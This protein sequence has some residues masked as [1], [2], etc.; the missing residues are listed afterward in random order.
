MRL[1]WQR[2]DE[3][4][5]SEE[6]SSSARRSYSSLS[7]RYEL[8]WNWRPGADLR[9]GLQGEYLTRD[10]GVSGVGQR[11][12]ALKGTGRRRLLAKWTL[13]GEARLAEVKSDEPAGS[14]RPWF[15]SYP[16]RNIDASLR[17]AWDPTEYLS[18]G[19][20]LVCPQAGGKGG[21]STMSVWN[22]PP[23]SETLR[24]SFASAVRAW[25]VRP[26]T[27]RSSGWWPD[28]WPGMLAALLTSPAPVSAAEAPV[29]VLAP[30][31]RRGAAD[32]GRSGC[33]P[34]LAGE[35]AGG[36]VAGTGRRGQRRYPG[37]L[38][39]LG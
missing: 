34:I 38:A 4:R 14:V 19:R 30:G 16:G 32:A 13:Q 9:L 24:P 39:P 7:Y 8:G 10:D 5:Y 33:G 29:L 27:G 2:Q 23:A 31:T 36:T 3:R 35:V 12:Y 28:F 21:G 20:Q 18:V 15:Y 11:E 26:A 37:G 6:S 25:A 17:V 22:P 1:R